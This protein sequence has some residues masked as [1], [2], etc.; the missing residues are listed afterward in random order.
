MFYRLK[1][2]TR[3]RYFSLR[4]KGIL[5]TPPIGSI[6]GGPVVLTQ[7]ISV[8]LSMYLVAVKFLYRH[9]GEA[10][11]VILLD[12]EWPRRSLD[13]LKKHV[14]PWKILY[15]KDQF[16]GKCPKGGTWERLL[17][18]ADL[19]GDNY[20]IQ[21]DADT[22]TLQSVP[23]I[24]ECVEAG[25]SFMIGT[26]KGQQPE[27]SAVSAER[28]RNNKSKH[29]Q[30]LAEQRLDDLNL[31]ENSRYARGQSSFAGFAP[32][33][34]SRSQIESLSERMGELLGR[35]KWSEWGSESFA[36]NFCVANSKNAVVLPWPKYTSY[37]PMADF[38][39]DGFAFL[40]FEGTHRFK[41]GT[42]VKCARRVIGDLLR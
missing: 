14:N 37:H 11:I 23:E 12:K 15:V 31:I 28:V 7:L 20:V 3:K 42:Y 32:G 30:I 39:M 10:R 40:H 25:A 24:T 2:Q 26:W 16:S 36:S 5:D 9:L 27:L 17:T 29:V 4:C 35:E 21:L 41:N 13:L 18:I 6:G 22:V 33:S 8:D 19:V 34:F 1:T 38:D